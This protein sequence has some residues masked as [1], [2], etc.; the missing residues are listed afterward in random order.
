MKMI[1]VAG[2]A[3]ILGAAM[4]S[5][6]PA[7][8]ITLTGEAVSAEIMDE[9][10]AIVVNTNGGPNPANLDLG[11]VP[12]EFTASIMVLNSGPNV[13]FTATQK[14]T[15]VSGADQVLK[16]GTINLPSEFSGADLLIA[17]GMGP[18]V[19]VGLAEALVS[20]PNGEMF[21]VRAAADDVLNTAQFDYSIT[22]QPIPLPA[23]VFM[24]LAALGG[25]GVLSRR[26]KAGAV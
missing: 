17:I 2:A 11:P 26:G 12:A 1:G 19:S 25:L 10:A 4:L 3:A 6:A 22:S 7:S 15:N 8:A 9:S 5:V 23:S 14:Y 13:G 18:F 21:F 24:L 16:F 20:I